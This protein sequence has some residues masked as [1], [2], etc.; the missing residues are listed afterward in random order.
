MRLINQ[1]KDNSLVIEKF[2]IPGA[3][4]VLLYCMIPQQ[5]K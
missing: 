2:Q 5:V 3:V 4:D 1:Q